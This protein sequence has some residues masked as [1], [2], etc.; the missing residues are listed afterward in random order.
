[1]PAL[2]NSENLGFV[3]YPLGSL[4][5]PP[6]LSLGKKIL[7]AAAVVVLLLKKVDAWKVSIA[8]VFVPAVPVIVDVFYLLVLL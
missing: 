5:E 8:V 1:M 7:A 6:N 4:I 2:S 3:L